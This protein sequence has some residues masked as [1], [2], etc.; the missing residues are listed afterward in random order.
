MIETTMK[1]VMATPRWVAPL[2]LV[3]AAAI[4]AQGM[5]LYKL[6]QD[7]PRKH[8]SRPGLATTAV[9]ASPAVQAVQPEAAALAATQGVETAQSAQ[10][11]P[12]R[13][14]AHGVLDPIDSL[15]DPWSR[16]VWTPFAEFEHMRRQMDRVF[17]DAFG[18]FS[19]MPPSGVDAERAL[20]YSPRTDLEET[21]DAYVVSMDLPGVEKEQID[22]RLEDRLLTVSGKSDETTEVR[23][24]D[25][26]LRQERRFGSFQRAVSLPGPVDDLRLE[27][28]CSNGVLV[29][30]VP[31]L[32]DASSGRTVEVK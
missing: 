17:D 23:E 18:R 32:P 27:A 28:S 26:I 4:V 25:Q 3:F 20:R 12:L 16:D 15:W 9:V 31:K 7:M 2:A 21:D 19:L 1:P 22:V 10:A 11:A 5:L 13:P 6:W 8:P 30:T 29:V 14:W 24:G